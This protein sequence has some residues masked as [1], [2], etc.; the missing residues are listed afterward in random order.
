MKCMSCHHCKKFSKEVFL[1]DNYQESEGKRCGAKY[2]SE[3]LAKY[4]LDAEKIRECP[5]WICLRCMSRCVCYHCAKKGEKGNQRKRKLLESESETGEPHNQ[6]DF[7]R[8]L[9]ARIEKK[10]EERRERL[11]GRKQKSG[12]EGKEEEARKLYFGEEN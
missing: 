5:I 3:C 12:E 8:E 7:V 1:C 6:V 9:F 10:T 2:C 4:N 11:E